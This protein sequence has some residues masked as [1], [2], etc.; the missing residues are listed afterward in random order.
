MTKK[1][2]EVIK[3]DQ[4]K[5][6][7]AAPTPATPMTLIEAAISQNADIDRLEKLWELQQRYEAS[8]ARKAYNTAMAAFRAECPK[9]E[10]NKRVAFAT[11]RG[12]TQYRHAT[13]DH[14]I[15]VIQPILAKHG[16]SY[17]WRTEQKGSLITVTC[18]VTHI[19]GHSESTSMFGEPDTSGTKNSIQAVGSTVT[20]L[21]RYTLFSILGLAAGDDTDGVVEHAANVAADPRAA[22]KSAKTVDELRRIF[23]ALTKE[24]QDEYMDLMLARKDEIENA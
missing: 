2:V 9:I 5:E 21:Q 4:V 8:E 11:Q 6:S 14:A 1:T 15:E 20:Y 19:A 7:H 17:S 18:I 22:I 13:L 3:Q 12:N 24:Q 23:K 16:L 10:K